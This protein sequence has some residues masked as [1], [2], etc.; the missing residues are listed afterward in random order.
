MNGYPSGNKYQDNPI[1][2]FKGTIVTINIKID[3]LN[4]QEVVQ[5]TLDW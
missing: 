4:E 3:N 2:N 1:Y 5:D